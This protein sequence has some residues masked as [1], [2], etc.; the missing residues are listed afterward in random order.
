MRDRIAKHNKERQPTGTGESLVIAD[1]E[2]QMT[3][4]GNRPSRPGLVAVAM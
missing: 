1:E 4:D 3:W 2:L